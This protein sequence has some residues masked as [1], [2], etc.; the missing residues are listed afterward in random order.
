MADR[1]FFEGAACYEEGTQEDMECNEEVDPLQALDASIQ[2]YINKAL[3]AALRPITA[4]QKLFAKAQSRKIPASSNSIGESLDTPRR[5]KEKTKHWPHEE[6]LSSL[7][8]K[9]TED[10]KYCM[11]STKHSFFFEFGY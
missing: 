2:Q 5:C 11:P 9:P 8:Q 4:Q 7:E 3:A 6:V 1:N 10:H